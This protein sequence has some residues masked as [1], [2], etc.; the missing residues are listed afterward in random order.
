MLP[1][2]KVTSR[3]KIGESVLWQRLL[4]EMSLLALI[5]ISKRWILMGDT[6]K[7]SSLE[8]YDGNDPVITTDNTINP[9]EKERS[10]IIIPQ[11]VSH[12]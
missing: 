5:L 8:S 1:K 7:F 10:V 9:V 11:D 4:S 6:S 3:R 12:Y 2:M